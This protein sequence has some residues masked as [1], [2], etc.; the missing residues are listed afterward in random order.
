MAYLQIAARLKQL[1][2]ERGMTQAQ[3]AHHVGVTRSAFSAYENGT[4]YPSYDTLI[5]LAHLFSVS[6]VTAVAYGWIDDA[7]EIG[8]D[9]PVTRGEAVVW[10]NSIFEHC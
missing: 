3:V 5:S 8:P 10:V 1:R 4:R 2:M 7:S 9:R 6:I